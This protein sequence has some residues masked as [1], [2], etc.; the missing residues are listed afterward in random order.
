MR[1]T[2]RYL[3]EVGF[4]LFYLPILCFLL[5]LF[6]MAA[7]YSKYSTKLPLDSSL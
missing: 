2:F 4:L 5:E 7:W 3:T 6:A 1:Q